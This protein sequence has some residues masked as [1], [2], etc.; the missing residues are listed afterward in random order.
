MSAGTQGSDICA[1]NYNEPG[2]SASTETG[3]PGCCFGCS[4]DGVGRSSDLSLEEDDL[5]GFLSLV[6]FDNDFEVIETLK[7][8]AAET[9]QKVERRLP[10]GGTD[11]PFVR[12]YLHIDSGLGSAYQTIYNAQQSGLVFEHIP[13]IHACYQLKDQRV[14]LMDFV[15][16][17]TLGDVVDRC[18]ASPELALEVFPQV[19]EA[20]RELHER[21]ESAVIHR[22][23]KPSN[24]ILSWGKLTLIDF[25][26]ARIFNSAS[27]SDTSHFGT[28]EYA[29]PEQFGFG[30]TDV[31]SD[32][33]SLG[34][35]LFYLFTGRTPSVED[36]A[37]GFVCPD[38]PAEFLQVIS[39]A[40]AFDP[41]NRYA[42]VRELQDAFGRASAQYRAHFAASHLTGVQPAKAAREPQTRI[43]SLLERIPIG[44]GIAWN[45][46]LG[47]FWLLF[48]AV[49]LNCCFF[50]RAD[51]PEAGYPLWVRM[52][53][54][55][56]FMAV[57]A[58][59]LCYELADRRLL[60]RRFPA[61]ARFPLL[62]EF[63][64]VA[65]AV[66]FALAVVMTICVQ[67]AVG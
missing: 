61:L 1:P 22:D 19:C 31:R 54:Y 45:V 24:I 25:G 30:Q 29:P 52:V 4:V 43:S 37:N 47:L 42:S 65:F 18:G 60:R 7:Q 48:V 33:Y 56:L 8:T 32:V 57:S 13:R 41:A 35:L 14:V 9:T 15:H 40:C 3:L 10:D 66:P 5:D 50:P 26:I 67:G 59:C 51:L 16:G 23:L 36:R 2:D 6:E 55:L 20:V 21:F 63:V 28:R 62:V 38:V 11:G 53:E 46:V 34:A 27:E 58:T 12:K 17:E 44:L 49:C 64:V 39:T